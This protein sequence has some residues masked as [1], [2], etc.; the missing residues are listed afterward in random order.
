ME[1]E[2]LQELVKKLLGIIKKQK[3]R[4]AE[5]EEQV[6]EL[7]ATIARLKIPGILQNPLRRIS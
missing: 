6:L 5:F 1:G 7:K 4:I 3:G 2:N